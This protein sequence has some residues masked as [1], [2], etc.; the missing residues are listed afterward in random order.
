MSNKGGADFEAIIKLVLWIVFAMVA[1]FGIR[2]LFNSLV[3]K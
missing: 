1:I 2:F 3:G